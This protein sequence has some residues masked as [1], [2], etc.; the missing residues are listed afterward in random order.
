MVMGL[1]RLEDLDRVKVVQA[2][3]MAYKGLI[4]IDVEKLLE[5][6]RQE[7]AEADA[8]DRMEKELYLEFMEDSGV[9][10]SQRMMKALEDFAKMDEFNELHSQFKGIMQDYK[11][12]KDEQEIKQCEV[13]ASV[14]KQVTEVNKRYDDSREQNRRE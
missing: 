13:R 8:K 2:E 4:K 6:Y 7:R 5:K 10:S 9:D 12:K 11:V 14:D 1:E 3:R